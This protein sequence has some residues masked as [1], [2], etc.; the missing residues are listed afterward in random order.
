MNKFFGS[1]N[2][3]SNRASGEGVHKGRPYEKRCSVGASDQSPQGAGLRSRIP[4]GRP[5]SEDALRKVQA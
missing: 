2:W 1:R 3:G 5:R 4:C